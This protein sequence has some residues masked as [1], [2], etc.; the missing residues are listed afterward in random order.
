M[1]GRHYSIKRF[2]ILIFIK[3]RRMPQTPLTISAAPELHIEALTSTDEEITGIQL[4]NI[5]IC[6]TNMDLDAMLNHED[7]VVSINSG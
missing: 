3:I 2:A 4:V 7:D 5:T 6:R 1:K